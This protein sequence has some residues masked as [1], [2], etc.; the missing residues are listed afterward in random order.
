MKF[1]P[2]T[3]KHLACRRNRKN[4]KALPSAAINIWL[5]ELAARLERCKFGFLLFPMED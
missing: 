3:L 5:D 2:Q 1:W 4:C